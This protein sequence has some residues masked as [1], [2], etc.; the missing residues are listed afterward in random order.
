MNKSECHFQGNN[1]KLDILRIPNL[2]NKK[3]QMLS[4]LTHKQMSIHQW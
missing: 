4:I 1:H 3:C 2:Y